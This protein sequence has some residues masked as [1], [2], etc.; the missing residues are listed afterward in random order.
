MQI[1]G[2]WLLFDHLTFG[3]ERC[4]HVRIYFGLSIWSAN[5]YW[6]K[7]KGR[8]LHLGKLRLRRSSIHNLSTHATYGGIIC[9]AHS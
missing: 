6:V 5:K 2:G 7:A 1:P 3:V 8:D 9:K 4:L